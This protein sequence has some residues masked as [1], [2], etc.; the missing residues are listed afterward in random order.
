MTSSG[1]PCP[2][3]L[4]IRLALFEKQLAAIIDYLVQN[5]R[6]GDTSFRPSNCWKTNARIL[7]LLFRTFGLISLFWK[8]KSRRMRSSC[9]V[10][11]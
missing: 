6:Y 3:Y 2:R 4:W 9:R 1:V 11:V 8:N 10:C 7:S 5:S